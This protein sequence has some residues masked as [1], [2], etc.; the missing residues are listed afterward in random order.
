MWDAYEPGGMAS[1]KTGSK[2]WFTGKVGS[3]KDAKTQRWEKNRCCLI[4]V[5]ASWRLERSGREEVAGNLSPL[6]GWFHNWIPT[7]G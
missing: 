6:R 3:R 7:H 5:L 1:N 2:E 4:L